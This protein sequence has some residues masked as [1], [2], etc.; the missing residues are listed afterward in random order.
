MR[1]TIG[2]IGAGSFGTVLTGLLVG[3]GGRA[4]VHD[5]DA[6]LVERLAR[7]GENPRYL[8]GYRMEGRPEAAGTLGA[9][10]RESDIIYV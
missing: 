1:K 3:N 10:C 5:R 4:L 6:E 2:V 9:L 8:P 7:D